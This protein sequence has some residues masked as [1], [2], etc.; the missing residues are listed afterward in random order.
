MA[1]EIFAAVRAGI[2]LIRRHDITA[3]VAVKTTPVVERHIR[4]PIVIS[5]QH[6]PHEQEEIQQPALFARRLDRRAAIPFAEHFG[7]H[8]RMG[9][10]A[11]GRCRMWFASEHLVRPVLIPQQ[12]I[13]QYDVER[14]EFQIPEANRLR[15]YH[16]RVGTAINEDLF[17]LVFD[18]D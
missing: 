5:P 11:G 16:N 10:M 4:G 13:T 3:A 18:R 12:L 14:T 1:A 17:K 15:A 9:D 8:V 2:G 7:I 6:L